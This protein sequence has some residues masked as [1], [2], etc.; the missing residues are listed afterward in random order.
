MY[1]IK[2]KELTGL[3]SPVQTRWFSTIE[4]R[5]DFSRRVVVVGFGQRMGS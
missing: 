2:Y 3:G 4:E 1:W 5:F